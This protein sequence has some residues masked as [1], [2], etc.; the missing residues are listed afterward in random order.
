MENYSIEYSSSNKSINSLESTKYFIH[1]DS[2]EEMNRFLKENNFQVGHMCC[3][4]KGAHLIGF[5]SYYEI[6]QIKKK[7]LETNRQ[8][9][10][11][12]TYECPICF[13]KYDTSYQ[14]NCKHDVCN[15]CIN[16]IKIHNINNSCPIC[17]APFE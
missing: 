11:S 6:N 16:N 17:R 3:S 12:P 4:G 8:N 2:S 14:L 15:E 9:K 7:F 13:Y 5:T 10:Y 1:F